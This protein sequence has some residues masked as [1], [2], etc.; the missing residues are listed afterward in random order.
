[1]VAWCCTYCCCIP[2]LWLFKVASF[3]SKLSELVSKKIWNDLIP[4]T[5]DKE[6]TVNHTLMIGIIMNLVFKSLHILSI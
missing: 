4:I 3:T 6:Q 1:M 5:F 2:C